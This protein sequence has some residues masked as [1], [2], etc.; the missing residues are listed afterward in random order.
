MLYSPFNG[1]VQFG[2]CSR[3]D[4]WEA[5]RKQVSRTP[6]SAKINRHRKLK[7]ANIA[8]QLQRPYIEVRSLATSPA[9]SAPSRVLP[10]KDQHRGAS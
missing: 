1:I 2:V 7:L 6:E 8:F 5:A 4:D 9:L 10:T 3:S